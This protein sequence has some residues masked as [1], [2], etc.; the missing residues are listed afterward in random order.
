MCGVAGIIDLV[1]QRLAPEGVVQRMA[2]A[3]THR[4]PDEEGFLEQPGISLASRRLSIVDLADGQQPMTNEDRSIFV[5]FNGELFDYVERREELVRQGHRF[6]THQEWFHRDPIAR[7][8]ITCLPSP[9]CRD[10]G[11]V[12]KVFNSCH[13]DTASALRREV[14]ARVR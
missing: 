6:R 7:D 3:I 1:G 12:S 13:Q 8:S 10:R 11:P 4:G 2:R 9:R 5:V 14:R